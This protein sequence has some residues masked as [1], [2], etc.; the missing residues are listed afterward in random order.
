[1]S[2]IV[3]LEVAAESFELGRA[4]AVP[5]RSDIELED[6]VPLGGDVVPLFWL[7]DSDPADFATEVEQH[8]AVENLTVFE[9]TYDRTLY[10]LQWNASSDRLLSA[11]IDLDGF[12]L[13]AA[14]RGRSWTFQ[15]RFSDHGTLSEFS[16]RCESKNITFDVLGLYNRTRPEAGPWYGLS[17][18]QY[19]TL[20]LAIDEGYY[21]IPRRISTQDLADKLGVSDQAVT[22][23]L[24]RAI[25][26]LV[27]NTLRAPNSD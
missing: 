15:V 18:P 25:R 16:E 3:E 24:R 2:V 7:H 11:I 27:D 21:D 19:E 17:E 1:M 23:R 9:Q 10:A 13:S 6:V 4:L 14:G 22:E 20:N 12:L 5:G 8:E 26:T